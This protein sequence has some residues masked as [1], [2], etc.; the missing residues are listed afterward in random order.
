MHPALNVN[1]LKKEEEKKGRRGLNVNVSPHGSPRGSPRASPRDVNL[2][3]KVLQNKFD[4][5]VKTSDS[6]TSI[7]NVKLIRQRFTDFQ[8]KLKQWR[9]RDRFRKRMKK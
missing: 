1:R 2:E 4:S 5:F 3:L 7:L 8:T 6:M 9:L